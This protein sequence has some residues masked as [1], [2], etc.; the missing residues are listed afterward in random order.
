MNYRLFF[1]IMKTNY[2]NHPK[3][4][5]FDFVDE[6]ETKK[7]RW[8]L[9]SLSNES[10]NEFLTKVRNSY[11]KFMDIPI[12]ETFVCQI[13]NSSFFFL[14]TLFFRKRFENIGWQYLS[15]CVF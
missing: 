10:K 14:Y 1:I 11:K 2:T 5:V 7:I 15:I 3:L 13:S 9:E 12:P 4:F 8:K 6:S